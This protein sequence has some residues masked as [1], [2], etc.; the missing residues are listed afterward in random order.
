MPLFIKDETVARLAA[1]AAALTGVSKT[2]AVR[3][4]LES[5]IASLEA[6]ET[7]SE[8]VARI[9]ARARTAGLRA[10]GYD[11]KELMDDLSGGL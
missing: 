1:K 2:R 8:S 11:D 5:H 6:R 3:Q 9:Q 10:D 7:L 4:A